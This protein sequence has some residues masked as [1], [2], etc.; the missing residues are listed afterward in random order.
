MDALLKKQQELLEQLSKEQKII[1]KKLDDIISNVEGLQS[2]I[3]TI[4]G[5]L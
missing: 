2:D 3:D 4:R 1:S 5:G